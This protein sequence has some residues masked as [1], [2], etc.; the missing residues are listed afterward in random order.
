MAPPLVRH[1]VRRY[2]LHEAGEFAV[3]APEQHPSL[4][5]VHVRGNRKIDEIWPGLSEV[6]IGLLRDVDIIIRAPAEV[7]R[8][9]LQLGSRL[10]KGVFRH[11]VGSHGL[12][13]CALFIRL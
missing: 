9:Q 10:L 7:K 3:D 4:R 1:F 11:A 5:R 6:E 12:E 8:A 13:E 2:L